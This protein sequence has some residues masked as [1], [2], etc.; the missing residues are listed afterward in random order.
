MSVCPS[1]C[2]LGL[3]PCPVQRSRAPTGVEQHTG[4]LFAPRLAHQHSP[5]MRGKAAPPTVNHVVSRSFSHL[6]PWLRQVTG[7]WPLKARRRLRQNAVARCPYSPGA[8]IYT[9]VTHRALVASCLRC[10]SVSKTVRNIGL[11]LSAVFI[12]YEIGMAGSSIRIPS[13][14]LL[15]PSGMM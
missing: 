4:M 12:K 7:R 11:H 15:L 13:Y 8:I 1:N 10:N 3:R 5:Q 6:F 9:A 2:R 14:G